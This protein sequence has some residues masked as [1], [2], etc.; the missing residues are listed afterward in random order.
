MFHPRL[1]HLV[2]DTAPVFNPIKVAC[3]GDEDAVGK[4][5]RLA[6]LCN[7]LKMGNYVLSRYAAFCAVRWLR[8]LTD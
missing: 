3:Y 8:Q 6:M 1:D 7:P 5:K 4:V 2:Y